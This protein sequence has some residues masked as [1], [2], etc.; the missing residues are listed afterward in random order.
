MKLFIYQQ[1]RTIQTNNRKNKNMKDITIKLNHRDGKG[2][3]VT[4]NT[5]DTNDKKPTK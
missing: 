1:Y 5:I 3:M 4:R 2:H